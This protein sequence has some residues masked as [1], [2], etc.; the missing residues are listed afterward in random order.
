[1]TASSEPWVGRPL[2]RV[3]DDALLR[4]EGRFLD[5]LSP[6]AHSYHAAVVRSQLAHARITV[7]A[8]AALDAPG[9][10][11]VLTG[12]D[13]KALSRPFP[14]GID[15]GTPQYA[16]AIDTVRY[17]GEPI[18][19][20]VARDRYLAEDAAELVDVDYDALDAVLDPVAAAAD[21][22][23][24]REF[25]YGDVSTAMAEADLVLSQTFHVPRFTC[26]PVECYAVV[27]DWDATAGRLTAWANFQGPFTLHG[28]A[29]AALGLKGDRLR[30]LTP[31]DSGGSFGVKSSVFT[32]IVLMG[33]AS[34][35]LGVPVTWIEDRLEH[36]AS[37]AA[38]TGRTTEVEAGFTTEGQ[39]LALRYDAIED[40]GAYVRAPEPATLY[41]MH[42]SLTGAYTVPNVAVRNRVVLTNT[43]PSGLNRGFGGPQLYFGL[44][45]T[46][47]IAARRLGL[48]PAE[49][50]RRNLIPTGAMPYRTP[51]GALYDSGN[52][53]ACLDHALELADYDGL[54][55]RVVTA[56]ADGQ[57]AGIGLACI[58]EPSISNMG[59][60]TLA[61]TADERALTLPKSGNA[62]GASISINPLGGITV[63]LA[64]TP[65]G[66]GHRTV[67]AQVVADTLGCVPD[68]VTVLA[69]MDTASVPWTVASGSYSS[70]FSGVAVGAVQ[71]AALK[72]RA[73]IDAIRAHAGD[74]T[75]SLRRVAGMA[76]WNP[77]GLPAG[78]EPGLSAVAFWAPPTLDPPDHD[79]RIASSASHGFIVD[80]CAV[81]V[82]RETGEVRVLDY[83]TVHDAGRL[84]N[85]LLADG[86]VM[87]GFTHGLAAALYE[88]HVYDKWGNLMTA[89]LVDYLTPTAPDIPALTIGHLSSPSPVTALGAK[90]IGEGNT[91]SAPVCVANA[92]ADAIARDD[93]ELPLTPPR[94]WQ[95]LN[96]RGA[97]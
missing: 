2:Q 95:L 30:L 22:V 64:T 92:V 40:V 16:T 10:I 17:V 42:G 96:E 78:E 38:A 57:L 94:V 80:I 85:P 74:D 25:E 55:A 8:S 63:R 3:E 45:R 51:S 23:H 65:Q 33:L 89:S 75:L 71:A 73:K 12:E 4:G 11:G 59:Y 82:E 90:G 68:D 36:L 26:T 37:S 27:A 61:Q 14:A 44:E 53:A 86:Q 47:A 87:G 20:V 49:L 88:R 54:R 9:V 66:Q 76:H 41:R 34:R 67:C 81:E 13:V 83:I 39:L 32:Y 6:V 43:Q 84:L 24:E 50:A 70:R 31:P 19:V 48:D 7:D 77:E 91:M 35:H 29:A 56:R 60:I 62:E 18:A 97:S 58:V 52:Y 69:E 93:V 1:M 28:V 5:D 15:S 72:L 46:M 21:A 79:D